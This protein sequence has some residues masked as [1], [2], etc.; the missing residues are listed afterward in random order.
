MNKNFLSSMCLSI[1]VLLSLPIDAEQAQLETLVIQSPAVYE[2]SDVVPERVEEVC[3]S[4]PKFV[5]NQIANKLK[6]EN[7][8]I[9]VRSSEPDAK[10]H[11]KYMGLTITRLKAPSPGAFFQSKSL[12]VLV[13]LY[14]D[15][16]LRAWKQ[17]NRHSGAPAHGYENCNL[18]QIDAEAIA[19]DVYRWLQKR[20]GK[21]LPAN[22]KSSV[23]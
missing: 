19:T 5:S 11:D 20:Q 3:Q 15:G 23:R 21:V 14:Q 10:L 2:N 4:L 7:Y 8:A 1:S 13:E 22:L 17:F 12:T 9:V 18:L 6:A 16:K